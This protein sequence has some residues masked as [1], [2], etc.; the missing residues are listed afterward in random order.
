MNK[1]ELI[2]RFKK[3]TGIYHSPIEY[4]KK[5]PYWFI[6][7]GRVVLN[8]IKS[9]WEFEIKELLAILSSN[10]YSL[11]VDTVANEVERILNTEEGK[12]F[13]SKNPEICDMLDQLILSLKEDYVNFFTLN[14]GEYYAVRFYG[15]D[16]NFDTVEEL[17]E[18]FKKDILRGRCHNIIKTSRGEV[19]LDKGVI[20]R[21][22][23]V[24]NINALGCVANINGS[25][26]L[27]N[28]LYDALE[29]YDIYIPQSFVEDELV[30]DTSTGLAGIVCTNY[31]GEE[32]L[33]P[34]SVLVKMY[35]RGVEGQISYQR[36]PMICCDCYKLDDEKRLS[37][38]K[39][40]DEY[41]IRDLMRKIDEIDKNGGIE[42]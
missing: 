33:D 26:K 6:Q 29:C 27:S 8:C 39:L 7:S 41:R 16:F 9:D 21:S 11:G 4:N 34:G 31:D 24:A 22:I 42:L 36:I 23:G 10:I 1:K 14:E 32:D 13:R 15:R 2:K 17:S 25:A 3:A 18:F 35:E 38:L 37:I 19:D 30:C 12:E 20:D 28:K 40:L 5:D